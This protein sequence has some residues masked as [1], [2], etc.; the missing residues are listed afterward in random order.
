MG[1]GGKKT[2]YVHGGPRPLKSAEKERK[3]QMRT[4]ESGERKMEMVKQMKVNQLKGHVEMQLKR[5]RSYIPDDIRER[6]IKPIDSAYNLKGAARAA[7]EYY[8][9]PGDTSVPGDEEA[10]NL[11]DEFAGKVWDAPYREGEALV[12]KMILYAASLHNVI[13]HTN[14]A[15]KVFYEILDYDPQD[16]FDAKQRILR[17]YM[18]IADAAKARAL[19]EKFSDDK[20]CCF[21]YTKVLIEYISFKL[22]KEAGSSE[23]LCNATLE[24]ACNTNPYALYALTYNSVFT[25]AIE[26]ASL[27]RSAP[28]GSV[29]DAISFF[30]SD[31]ELWLDVEGAIEWLREWMIKKDLPPPLLEEERAISRDG[32]VEGSDEE[33][34]KEEQEER[35]EDK[36]EHEEAEYDT[37]YHSALGD[38][39]H[40][41]LFNE[42]VA[43]L[44]DEE[45]HDMYVGMVRTALEMAEVI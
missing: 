38:P 21:V 8:K 3:R 18:D 23:E 7:R 19:I 20:S 1:K 33:K 37:S 43:S 35:D 30:D 15:I 13:G 6:M 17:C 9:P 42:A 31:L 29:E 39:D 5:M 10:R 4:H 40:N 12:E 41:P 14:H 44:S 2:K 45:R 36:G 24:H 34:E 26:H 11:L 27:I 32:A 28:E 22:L 16:H 25:D